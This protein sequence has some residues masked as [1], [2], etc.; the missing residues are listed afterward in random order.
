MA[1]VLKQKNIP[2]VLD[3]VPGVNHGFGDNTTYW[4]QHVLP[5]FDFAQKYIDG[6][7]SKTSSSK[8]LEI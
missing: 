1:N 8:S 5:V 7:H 6:D 2:Y 4:E 3:L